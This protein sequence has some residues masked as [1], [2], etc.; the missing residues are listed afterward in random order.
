MLRRPLPRISRRQRYVGLR[1]MAR[2][3]VARYPRSI[4]A[5]I[6]AIFIMW[7]GRGMVVPFIVIFF[8]QIVGLSG[9]T[10][11]AGIAV[12]SLLGIAFALV[13]A[14]QID[15]RG[16]RPVLIGAVV[17]VGI[18]TILLAWAESQIVFLLFVL[19]LY[20][21]SQSYWP[22]VDT[23]TSSIANQSQVITSM[24]MVRVANALGIGVGGFIGGLM[25]TGGGLI[26]YRIMFMTGGTLV[27]VA[28]LLIWLLVPNV[29]HA[30]DAADE[31]QDPPGWRRVTE[32]RT[33]LFSL[34]LLFVLVL[35]FTQ[36]QMS[37]PPFL[38]A[39]AGVDEGL[40]GTLFLLNT[41]GVILFQVPVAARIDRANPGSVLP[42]GAL[43]W[44]AAFLLMMATAT[45]SVAAFA[46]FIAFTAGELIFMPVSAIFAV[47]LAPRRLRGRYFTLLSITWG[48]SFAIA[49]LAAGW[50]QDVDEPALLWPAMAA[51]MLAA[52]LGSLRLR[53]SRRLQ[54]PPLDEGGSEQPVQPPTT[55]LATGE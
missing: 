48:G 43:L 26:E 17:L 4:W 52:A 36:V 12:A 32:D 50:M 42:L 16:G 35:G 7:T 14:S 1:T 24:S 49:T 23:V 47:R 21:S 45:Q 5:L 10:V 30:D 33:F 29:H 44:T 27:V 37:V 46:V 28:A 15:A 31:P 20:V 40:I 34:A 38:R 53:N 8:T 51:L 39:E 22:A 25:V 2:E 55:E 13:T 3:F 11:G 18:A 41:I 9:A 54:P 6:I 19:L